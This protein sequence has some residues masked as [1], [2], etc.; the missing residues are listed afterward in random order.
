[1]KN[2]YANINWLTNFF[3][4]ILLLLKRLTPIQAPAPSQSPD[5]R[6]GVKV[7]AKCGSRPHWPGCILAADKEQDKFQAYFYSLDE[8]LLMKTKNIVVH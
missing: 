4:A 2:R 1:L 7:F 6:R 3:L 5:L 8:T